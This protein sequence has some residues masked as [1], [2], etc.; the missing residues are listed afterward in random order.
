MGCRVSLQVHAMPLP[1]STKEV[2]DIDKEVDTLEN[3]TPRLEEFEMEGIN[4]PPD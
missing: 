2:E 3:F 4:I 1:E